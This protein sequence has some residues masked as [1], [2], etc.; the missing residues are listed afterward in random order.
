VGFASGIMVSASFFSHLNPSLEEALEQNLSYP[1][2]VPCL[3]GFIIGSAFIFCL[4]LVIPYITKEKD[5]T[6]LIRELNP[7]DQQEKTKKIFKLLLAVTLHNIREG[8]ACG[9]VFGAAHNEK[10]EDKDEALTFA[11]GLSIGIVIQ[12]I[13]EGVIVALPVK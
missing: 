12:N 6:I 7:E 8:I 13:P 3:V 5:E 4:G 2:W 11:I 9:L 1:Y 10:G